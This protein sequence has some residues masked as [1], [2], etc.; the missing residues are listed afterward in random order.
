[1]TSNSK[2]GLVKPQPIMNDFSQMKMRSIEFPELRKKVLQ[3][4]LIKLRS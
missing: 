2:K 1:M 3:P 4:T